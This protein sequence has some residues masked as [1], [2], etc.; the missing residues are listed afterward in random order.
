MIATCNGS[1][2]RS[3]IDCI[4][5]NWDD[6]I[7]CTTSSLFPFQ[8]PDGFELHKKD[9]LLSATERDFSL[10]ILLP[11]VWN[12]D[13]FT[14]L[15]CFSLGFI[16]WFAVP[17]CFWPPSHLYSSWMRVRNQST[18]DNDIKITNHNLSQRANLSQRLIRQVGVPPV[19]SAQTL[20]FLLRPP[21]MMVV[22]WCSKPSQRPH[23]TNDN[24][25]DSLRPKSQC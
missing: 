18:R 25:D 7:C 16:R 19:L 8:P 10:S 9:T 20:F 23:S 5:W 1:L 4:S 22:F 12:V 24:M 15:S 14:V 6:E 17:L 21:S 13:S 3:L 11:E 2:Y